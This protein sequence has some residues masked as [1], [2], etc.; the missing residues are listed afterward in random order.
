MLMYIIVK[1][2]KWNSVQN[3]HVPGDDREEGGEVLQLPL[4]ECQP[5]LL[6]IAGVN[7]V[8]GLRPT[9]LHL[10]PQHPVTRPA[11]SQVLQTLHRL[12]RVH[13]VDVHQHGHAKQGL[14]NKIM[15]CEALL[16]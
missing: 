8:A 2:Q 4:S 10:H 6:L 1:K 5:P 12:P 9:P 7:V 14:N 16:L 15:K 11:V 13:N 3:S